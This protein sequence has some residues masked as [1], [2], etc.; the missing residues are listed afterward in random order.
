MADARTC[1]IQATVAPGMMH[2][3]IPRER[4]RMQCSVQFFGRMYNNEMGGGVRD[5]S[6]LFD[7]DNKRTNGARHVTIAMKSTNIISPTK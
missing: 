3:E 4:T 5:C 1:T 6:Y 7:S 2:C